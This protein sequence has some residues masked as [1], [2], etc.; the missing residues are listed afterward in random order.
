MNRLVWIGL[1]GGAALMAALLLIEERQAS[2]HAHLSAGAVE[3]IAP[4]PAPGAVRPL[5]VAQA[6]NWVRVILARPLFAR[7]RRPPP[8]TASAGGIRAPKELPRLSAVLVSASGRLA[9]FAP[10]EGKPIVVSQGG[11]LGSFTVATIA[12][13][14][15]TVLGPGG[16]QVLQPRFADSDT[17]APPPAIPGTPSI[18]GQLHA[19]RFAPV[20]L[21]A[22]PSLQSLLRAMPRRPPRQP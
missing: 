2:S 9:I 7:N 1:A 4:P 13:G 10:T 11:Q 8:A 19:G 18:L 6:N 14:E 16:R 22:P 3:A 20:P 21:P 5:V 17:D 15:V 12:P